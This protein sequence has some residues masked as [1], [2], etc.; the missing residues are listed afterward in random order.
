MSIVSEPHALWINQRWLAPG[1][2][3]CFCPPSVP[4]EVD[5][6][7]WMGSKDIPSAALMASKGERPPPSGPTSTRRHHYSSDRIGSLIFIQNQIQ[8]STLCSRD[9]AP[10]TIFKNIAI[11]KMQYLFFELLQCLPQSSAYSSCG[12]PHRWKSE[13]P[14]ACTSRVQEPFPVWPC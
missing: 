8:L 11:L 2:W 1:S 14:G 10:I 12:K 5:F 13:G 9:C 6:L 4:W 3:R 7:L